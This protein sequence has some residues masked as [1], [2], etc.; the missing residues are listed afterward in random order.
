MELALWLDAARADY[1]RGWASVDSELHGLCSR[2]GN[3]IFEDVYTKVAVVNRVYIA[4]ISRVVR[5]EEFRADP[6]AAVARGLVG[7]ADEVESSL[8]LPRVSDHARFKTFALT[9]I[10]QN[11]FIHL[12][13]LQADVNG[14]FFL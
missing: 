11:K 9:R 7:V 4:G 6:E 13:S 12:F 3:I 14:C 10:F 1:E 5:Y 2:K 8:S